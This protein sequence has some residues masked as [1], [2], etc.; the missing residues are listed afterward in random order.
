MPCLA[1]TFTPESPRKHPSEHKRETLLICRCTYVANSLF[2]CWYY[3]LCLLSLYPS[4]SAS[5]TPLVPN[6]SLLVECNRFTQTHT[7]THAPSLAPRASSV[8]TACYTT[9]ALSVINWS[10]RCPPHPNRG[11]LFPLAMA[12]TDSLMAPLPSCL[13]RLA[14]SFYPRGKEAVDLSPTAWSWHDVGRELSHQGRDDVA[15]LRL[16][17][18]IEDSWVV[19]CSMVCGSDCVQRRK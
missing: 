1:L 3:Y 5:L 10:L 4:S 14:Q 13:R 17:Q 11:P 16:I 19:V 2:S 8:Q 6:T 18:S 9:T 7:R 12:T 15:Q